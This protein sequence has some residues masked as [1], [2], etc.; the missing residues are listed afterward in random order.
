MKGIVYFLVI[1]FSVVGLLLL[2]RLS[3]KTTQVQGVFLSFWFNYKTCFVFFSKAFF[4]KANDHAFR[5]KKTKIRIVSIDNL[6][7]LPSFGK[8]VTKNNC[9]VMDF[10]YKFLDF[11]KLRFFRAGKG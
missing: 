9:H 11:L 3:K 6:H 8:L 2:G 1:F 5:I 4:D 7:S 10:A